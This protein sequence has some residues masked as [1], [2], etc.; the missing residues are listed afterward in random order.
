MKFR[1]R[2]RRFFRLLSQ[3]FD[4][5]V[6]ENENNSSEFCL[7]RKKAHTREWPV[8]AAGGVGG[9]ECPFFRGRMANVYRRMSALVM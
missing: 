6:V 2:A 8:S 4:S 5:E 9:P 7:S 3:V 1:H